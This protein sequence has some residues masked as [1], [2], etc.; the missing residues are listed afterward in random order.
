MRRLR[1]RRIWKNKLPSGSAL[2][3]VVR[4]S[5]RILQPRT[6]LRAEA[7]TIR[8]KTHEGMAT[9]YPTTMIRSAVTISLVPE[10]RGGPFVFWDDLTSGCR[11]AAELG[12]DAV[13]V[14]PPS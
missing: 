11:K 13:E 1:W 12:F 9:R 10:A 5:A 8:T 4:A 6:R 14:F 2:V 3:F 7:R